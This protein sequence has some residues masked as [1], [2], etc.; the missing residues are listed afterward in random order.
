M[1]ESNVIILSWGIF[2]FSI[3]TP[4]QLVEHLYTVQPVTWQEEVRLS[5]V[6][7]YTYQTGSVNFCL[8]KAS[9]AA[10]LHQLNFQ[11]WITGT[12]NSSNGFYQ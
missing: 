6:L 7:Q 8:G 3:L 12:L 11:W 4:R 2:E 1:K 10:L 5:L 9:P